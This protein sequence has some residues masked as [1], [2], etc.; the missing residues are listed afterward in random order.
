MYADVTLDEDAILS[1]DVGFMQATQF[2][3]AMIA[4]SG[5][6]LPG[7][8]AAA[9]ATRVGAGCFEE[10]T[11]LESGRSVGSSDVSPFFDSGEQI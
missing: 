10:I 4:E 7:S 3:E 5:S 11:N 6:C 8:S 9:N 2:S 1:V